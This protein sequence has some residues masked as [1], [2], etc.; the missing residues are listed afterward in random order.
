MRKQ[1]S[2]PYSAGGG[3]RGSSASG[4]YSGGYKSV[5]QHPNKTGKL[6]RYADETLM[7]RRD[8][9]RSSTV[10]SKAAKPAKTERGAKVAGT[11]GAKGPRVN[12]SKYAGKMKSLG[13]GKSH[14]AKAKRRS[15]GKSK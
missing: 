3:G 8:Y 5:P 13:L 1:G 12:P 15:N 10:Q 11:T 2:V 14:G 6:P 4:A 9:V 7:H